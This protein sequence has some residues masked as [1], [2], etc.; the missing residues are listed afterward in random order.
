MEGLSSL[1]FMDFVGTFKEELSGLFIG[2]MNS[3]VATVDDLL[4][5]ITVNPKDGAATRTYQHLVHY[6]HDLNED[7]KLYV[8][9]YPV[10]V[11]GTVGGH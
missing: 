3:T 8:T 7:G 5:H 10:T 2:G 9:Y 4:D 6:I 11:P 1:G